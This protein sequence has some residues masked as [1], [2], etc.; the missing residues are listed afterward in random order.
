MQEPEIKNPLFI[1]NVYYNNK[2]VKEVREIGT[3][4]LDRKISRMIWQYFRDRHNGENKQM[5][6]QHSVSQLIEKCLKEGKTLQI[7][8]KGEPRPEIVC[9]RKNV[10]EQ[11]ENNE[12]P[13]NVVVGSPMVN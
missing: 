10:E 12:N 3:T 1:R 13:I 11:A 5:K 9:L 4:K 6:K 2:I 7:T 8:Y